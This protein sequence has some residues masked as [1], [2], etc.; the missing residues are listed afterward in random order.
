MRPFMIA[1]LIDIKTNN[2]LRLRL[3]DIDTNKVWEVDYES[4][5]EDILINL[6]AYE[7]TN[8]NIFLEDS[9]TIRQHLDML[10][11]IA[12]TDYK[13]YNGSY[14]LIEDTYANII[15]KKFSIEDKYLV[16]DARGVLE[17]IDSTFIVLKRNIT[18]ASILF[19][20]GLTNWIEYMWNVVIEKQKHSYT[21]FEV[22]IKKEYDM[23]TTKC[24]L[25]GIDI[26]F[27]YR[28]D[29]EDVILTNY[30]G[31][32]QKVIIPKFITIIGKNAF[33]VFW[34]KRYKNKHI[35]S[36]KLNNGLKKISE[37]A[38]SFCKAK[39]LIVPT[40]VEI[41]EK[42]AFYNSTLLDRNLENIESS[43]VKL[44]N[45]STIVEDSII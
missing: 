37:G 45:K 28:V 26:Q 10:P 6:R 8:L 5:D 42:G 14:T 12:I 15:L 41:I 22:K 30:T 40:T 36:I 38:F 44:I 29:G 7:E 18:N 24:S 13:K 32:S 19:N 31:T 3:V 1:K 4:L 27:E 39:E 16:S 35:R 2:V 21:E 9:K 43:K 20:N 17:E 33:S 11:C 25:I 23:F 34:T